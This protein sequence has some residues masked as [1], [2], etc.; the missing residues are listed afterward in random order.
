MKRPSLSFPAPREGR[1][2]LGQ[3]FLASLQSVIGRI[4]DS[5]VSFSTLAKNNEWYVVL[6]TEE[7]K[8]K[9]LLA[10][11]LYVKVVVFWVRSSDRNQFRVRFKLAMYENPKR[12]D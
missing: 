4:Q 7:A 10:G 8:N 9:L 5:V 3:Y 2:F 12:V 6:K 1:F 11:Q